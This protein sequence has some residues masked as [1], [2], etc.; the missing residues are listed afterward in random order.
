MENFNVGDVVRLK[1]GGPKM[2]ISVVRSDDDG[3]VE[4]TW[5]DEKGVERGGVYQPALLKKSG[6][7]ALFA[8]GITE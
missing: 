4:T 5:F 2:T 6:E 3:R 7:P 8:G 1:S